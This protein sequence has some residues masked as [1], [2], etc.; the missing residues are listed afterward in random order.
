MQYIGCFEIENN[1]ILICDPMATDLANKFYQ[2]Q[3]LNVSRLR[4]DHVPN[5]IWYCYHVYDK[6][7]LYPV[8]MLITH[9]RYDTSYLSNEVIENDWDYEGKVCCGFGRMVCAMDRNYFEAEE[10]A[11]TLYDDN[12][13][14]E[15]NELK[16]WCDINLPADRNKYAL[17][18]ILKAKEK[19]KYIE[20]AEISHLLTDYV[21]KIKNSSLWSVDCMLHCDN[22]YMAA[23]TIKGG[24]VSKCSLDFTSIYRHPSS[25]AI[26]I[27]IDNGEPFFQ[28]NGNEER[29]KLLFKVV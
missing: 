13:V 24:A 19:E 12:V 15:I 17:L 11:Y 16:K 22:R 10:F 27:T 26:Y 14:Y 8:G 9:K 6:K 2:V 29:K 20:A 21:P 7:E 18:S 3:A 4:I 28:Q 1:N 23:G 25:A 5:G